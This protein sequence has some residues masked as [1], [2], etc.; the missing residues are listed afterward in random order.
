MWGIFI[1]LIKYKDTCK[2]KSWPRVCER[3]KTAPSRSYSLK[4]KIFWKE[5][6]VFQEMVSKRL[7]MYIIKIIATYLI[8]YAFVQN[9][10]HYQHISSVACAVLFPSL[11]SCLSY[12]PSKTI[13]SPTS[14]FIT[15]VSFYLILGHVAI[16]QS[17]LLIKRCKHFWYI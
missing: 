4:W 9:Q 15:T 1:S 13:K 14:G 12:L 17:L 2:R 5:Q 7:N 10:W 3:V 6:R 16:T 11:P 8:L